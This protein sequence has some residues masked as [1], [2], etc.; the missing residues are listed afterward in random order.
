ME[1]HLYLFEVKDQIGHILFDAGH[2][3]EF[4]QN[5]FNLHLCDSCTLKGREQ[6]A[7]E[8][9]SQSDAEPSLKRFTHEFSVKRSMRSLIHLHTPGPDEFCPI[10]SH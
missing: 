6:D 5:A 3:R 7:P 1:F 9:V 8:R 10:S 4:M 2:C